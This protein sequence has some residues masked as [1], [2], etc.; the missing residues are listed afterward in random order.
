MKKNPAVFVFRLQ[1]NIKLEHAVAPV[2]S[3]KL[4]FSTQELYYNEKSEVANVG[5]KVPERSAAIQTCL[6]GVIAE[7]QL[8]S[9]LFYKMLGVMVLTA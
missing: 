6:S 4:A 8:A 3:P 1:G 9:L 2:A 7:T 5:L